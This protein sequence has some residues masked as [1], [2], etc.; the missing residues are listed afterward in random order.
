MT[1]GPNSGLGHGTN[2]QSGDEPPTDIFL[3]YSG[4]DASAAR[5]IQS[6]LVAAGYRLFWDQQVPPGQDWDQWI[7]ARLSDARLVLVLWSRASIRSPNV[8]HE[9]M[10]SME[11]VK[12]LPISAAVSKALGEYFTNISET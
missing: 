5:S 10:L 4:Q 3:S 12:L 8:R 1:T 11:A 6:V 9:A 2:R 7:R